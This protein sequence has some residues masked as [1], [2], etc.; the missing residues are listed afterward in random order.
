MPVPPVAPSSDTLQAAPGGCAL[1]AGPAFT[2]SWIPYQG[3]NV[4][5]GRALTVLAQRDQWAHVE[6]SDG[7]QGWCP[8]TQ[9]VQEG[10]D[11]HHP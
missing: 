2:E 5:E 9:L 11:A 8:Q 3:G 4:P 1:R 7:A 10:A 6:L